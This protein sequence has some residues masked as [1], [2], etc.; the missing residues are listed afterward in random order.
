MSRLANANKQAKVI[1]AL[2]RAGF[3]IRAG[4]KH[5]IVV[6]ENGNFRSTIPRAKEL[7]IHT[8]RAILRQVGLS[9]EEFLGFYR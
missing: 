6:D 7:N 9:E 3:Q 2:K 4:G 1:K 5:Q 8:L